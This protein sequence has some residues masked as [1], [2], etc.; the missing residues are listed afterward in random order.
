MKKILQP[1]IQVLIVSVRNLGHRE[2]RVL[3]NGLYLRSEFNFNSHTLD[4]L[5]HIY[6]KDSRKLY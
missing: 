5:C 1:S 3:D 6:S 4:S 2:F